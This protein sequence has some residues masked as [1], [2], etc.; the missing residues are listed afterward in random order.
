MIR[1]LRQ[2]LVLDLPEP[3]SSAEYV[4]VVAGVETLCVG[5]VTGRVLVAQDFEW[6]FERGGLTVEFGVKWPQ[7][8]VIRPQS[9]AGSAI[10][11]RVGTPA[12]RLGSPAGA[13]IALT[14]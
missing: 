9:A 3:G 12:L 13:P 10:Y 2:M 5:R 1:P 4:R 14:V 8:L 11:R 6:H 7:L